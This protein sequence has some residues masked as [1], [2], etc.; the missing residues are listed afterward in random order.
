[1]M[2][3]YLIAAVFATAG[4]GLGTV[5]VWN[6][7]MS[8]NGGELV[9]NDLSLL[10]AGLAIAS[11]MLA[12]SAGAV[13]TRSKL[14]GALCVLAVIGCTITS[15]GYTLGRVGDKADDR[16]AEALEHNAKL[17]RAEQRVARLVGDVRDE[18]ARGG[19]G[20]KCR[21]L[22]E[23][24]AAAERALASLGARRVVDPAGERI[25]AVTAGLWSA[26]H[27]R[28]AHP[29][30]TAATL[31]LCVSLLLTVAGLIW[32]P[33]RVRE[34][35]V[36]IINPEPVDPILRALQLSGGRVGSNNELAEMLR[37]P[38]PRVTERVRLLESA[39]AVRTYRDGKSKVI[40]LV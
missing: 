38:A 26:D 13:W 28:T 33:A 12:A 10:V 25:E 5:N 30:I 18:A 9:F 34:T 24:L 23:D 11:A 2:F 3:R 29:V 16:A 37:L 14:V 32:S 7:A 39:G 20:P 19:C 4:V 8:I 35:R 21:A 36:E 31:E 40:E 27:Y 1:M 6:N 17:E 15:V 22:K